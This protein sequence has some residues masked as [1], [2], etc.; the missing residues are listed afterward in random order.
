MIGCLLAVVRI[1]RPA[2]VGLV[3][4]RAMPVVVPLIA[5]V[6]L[7]GTDASM[8]FRDLFSLVNVLFALLVGAAAADGGGRV[9]AAFPLRPLGGISYSLYLWQT[10][11]MYALGTGNIRGN[12][13][14]P[15]S[16]LA[17]AVSVTIAALST[18][19]VERPFRRRRQ[20]RER[21]PVG[22]IVVEAE[23]AQA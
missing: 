14:V 15:R 9:L 21:A 13:D 17:I 8:W 16:L 18:R 20:P 2:L 22:A 1:E 6:A 10:P 4:R 12:F 3:C 11:I 5:V 7:I 23:A 19:Y